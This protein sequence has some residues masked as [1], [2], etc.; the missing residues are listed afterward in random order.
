MHFSVYYILFVFS[1]TH[2]MSTPDLGSGQPKDLVKLDQAWV[3][4]IK[5]AVVG[6]KSRPIGELEQQGVWAVGKA[7]DS[8]SSLEGCICKP[9]NL[10]CYSNTAVRIPSLGI[11]VR[12]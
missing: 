12:S 5:T 9:L 11:V 3:T 1:E 10:C 8:A 2:S 7:P 6:T 4:E